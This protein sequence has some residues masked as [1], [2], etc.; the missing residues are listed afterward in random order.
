MQ[1]GGID[2]LTICNNF[3]LPELRER[4]YTKVILMDHVDWLDTPH[5]KELAETLAK[6]V[7]PGTGLGP[8]LLPERLVCWLMQG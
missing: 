7:A 6:Q 1:A 3:F 5:A 4:T 8:P 2:R